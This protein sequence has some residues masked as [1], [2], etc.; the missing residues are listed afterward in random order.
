MDLTGDN[1]LGFRS[2]SAQ[3][4]AAWARELRG[5]AGWIDLDAFASKMDRAAPAGGEEAMRISR[6]WLPGGRAPSLKRY[7]ERLRSV[8]GLKVKARAKA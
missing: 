8:H 6:P 2:L 7:Q 1:V 5:R 3:E 4:S